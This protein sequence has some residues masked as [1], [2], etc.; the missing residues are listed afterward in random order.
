MSATVSTSWS[1]SIR[2]FSSVVSMSYD[3]VRIFR[4]IF[5]ISMNF[6]ISIIFRLRMFPSQIVYCILF[7]S[8]ILLNVYDIFSYLYG[9][10]S[11]TNESILITY[12]IVVSILDSCHVKVLLVPFRWLFISAFVILEMYGKRV[13]FSHAEYS[14][15][16]SIFDYSKDRFNSLDKKGVQMLVFGKWLATGNSIVQHQ[17]IWKLHENEIASFIHRT[18]A[19]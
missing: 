7:A 12:F 9:R 3:S 5:A 14:A 18:Y 10:N 17:I 13:V 4:R 19:W 1:H 16:T 15:A 2:S 8:Q 6:R 11:E